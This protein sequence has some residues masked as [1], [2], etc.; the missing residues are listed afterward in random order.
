MNLKNNLVKFKAVVIGDTDYKEYDKLITLLTKEKG[1]VQVYAFNVR[2]P[3]S[4]NIGKI[5]LFSFGT[6]ELREDREK[7]SL[8]NVILNESFDDLTA[9]YDKICYAS[10][11]VELVDYFTYENI[12][13]ENIYD[14]LYFTLKAL[15]N[16]KIEN[17][18]V[19]RIFELKMI[20]YQGEYKDSEM[21]NVDNDTLKYTWDFVL[22]SRPNKLYSFKL[23]DEIFNLFDKEVRNEMI[24]K[25]N[26]KF[27]TLKEIEK[28]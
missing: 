26:Y 15:D 14:L 20:Q 6:F 24:S 8:E 12:E 21:L 28:L 4:K 9:D 25:V 27:K 19:R 23:N 18:L 17:K 22:N 13:S 11:F 16:N 10:Y 2:R 7:Y 5:R 1:K 3:N